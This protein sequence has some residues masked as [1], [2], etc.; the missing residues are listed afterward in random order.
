[1]KVYLVSFNYRYEGSG[2]LEVC[3]TL[4]VA[5]NYIDTLIKENEDDGTFNYYEEDLIWHNAFFGLS[6][7][8]EEKEVL[9]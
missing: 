9:E 7:E 8:I 3:S 6:Y 2:V 4:E 5:K 1:M